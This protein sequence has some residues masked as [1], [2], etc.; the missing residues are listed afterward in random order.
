[1]DITQLREQYIVIEAKG[2]SDLGGYEGDL[3]L[4][5]NEIEA[6]VQAVYDD[7]G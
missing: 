2:V 4:L 7:A 5:D 1:M 6:G 3:R